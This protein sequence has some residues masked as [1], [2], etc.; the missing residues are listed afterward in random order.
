MKFLLTEDTIHGL[1]RYKN[2]FLWGRAPVA[3][4]HFV[5]GWSLSQSV[6]NPYSQH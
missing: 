1:K 6:A 5:G 3:R 2:S 4:C